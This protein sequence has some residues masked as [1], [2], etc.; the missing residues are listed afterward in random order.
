[1]NLLG[2]REPEVYGTT[3]LAEID[4]K[5]IG[6]ASIYLH[7]RFYRNNG[8]SAHLEDIIIDKD[9]RGLGLGKKLINTIIEWCKEHKCYKIQLKLYC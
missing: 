5:L 2:E 8:M 4:T 7:K 1:M 9:Y 3:T 6:L